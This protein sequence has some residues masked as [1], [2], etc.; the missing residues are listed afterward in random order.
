MQVYLAY[1][2][3]GDPRHVELMI[4]PEIPIGFDESEVVT[5]GPNESGWS[6]RSWWVEKDGRELKR[7]S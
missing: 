1:N 2:E 6:K 3:E 4:D 5:M 7:M